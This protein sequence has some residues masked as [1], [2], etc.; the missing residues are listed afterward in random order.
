MASQIDLK[1]ARSASRTLKYLVESRFKD[2][3]ECLTAH[4]IFESSEVLD[5]TKPA[6]LVSLVNRTLQCGVNLYQLWDEHYQTVTGRLNGLNLQI[7]KRSDKSILLFCYDNTH[8][9]RHLSH[10][11]LLTILAKSGYT[12]SASSQELLQELTLRVNQSRGFPHEIGL[13]IGYPA[14]DVA[15][16]MGLIKIPFTC[17]G[18]WKIFGNPDQSLKLV[19]SHIMS[20]I[21]IGKK[22]TQCNSPLEC[23]SSAGSNPFF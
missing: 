16:F 13:F 6:N 12:T 22:L 23:I 5:G 15:A 7:L 20:R 21:N 11:G 14:K 3:V 17:Q 10:P 9:S 4:L 19:G 8:L 1:T 2:P 18:P